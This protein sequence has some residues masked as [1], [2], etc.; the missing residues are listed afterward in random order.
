ML[1]VLIFSC[2]FIGINLLLY[3]M[4]MMQGWEL[5]FTAMY[6]FPIYCYGKHR[7]KVWSTLFGVHTLFALLRLVVCTYIGLNF[8]AVPRPI[9]FDTTIIRQ[10]CGIVMIV[11]WIV[12]LI[13]MGI[14]FLYTT[15]KRVVEYTTD[16]EGL[17]NDKDIIHA[18]NMFVV[19]VVITFINMIV[20]VQSY[21]LNLQSVH[22]LAQILFIVIV[23]MCFMIASS[24]TVRT[25]K[26]KILEE[27]KKKRDAEMDEE[28]DG[29]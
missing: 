20:A 18:T 4:Q 27:E 5:I 1:G 3:S 13:V 21:A 8:E 25:R 23:S 10:F 15:S 17:N 19:T 26:E 11:S 12:W 14:F 6:C 28:I 22:I 9:V 29:E 7:Y 16:I 2:F 24:D